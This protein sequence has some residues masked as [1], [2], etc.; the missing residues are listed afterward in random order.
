MSEANETGEKPLPGAC[1]R[2]R[3]EPVPSLS[4]DPFK[5]EKSLAVIIGGR[6]ATAE[7]QFHTQPTN[8]GG[9]SRFSVLFIHG[10]NLGEITE[11]IF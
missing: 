1:P 4:P 7:P 5:Y 2:W 3:F 11:E 9:P 6:P 10:T 8:D